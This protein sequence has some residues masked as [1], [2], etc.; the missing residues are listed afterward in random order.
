MCSQ[1]LSC[2]QR[3]HPGLRPGQRLQRWLGACTNV[4]ATVLKEGKEGAPQ[5]TQ[6]P[7]YSTAGTQS[8]HGLL[9]VLACFIEAEDAHVSPLTLLYISI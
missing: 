6:L 9:F 2:V 5:P 8:P 1:L 4:G 7:Q 3:V